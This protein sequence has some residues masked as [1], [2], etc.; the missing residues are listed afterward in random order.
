MVYT[1]VMVF[2]TVDFNG[3]SGDTLDHYLQGFTAVGSG[4]ES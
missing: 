1:G 4:T 2:Q 3:S